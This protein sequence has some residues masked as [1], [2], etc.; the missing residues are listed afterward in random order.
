MRSEIY[1]GTIL[2]IED[3]EVL[4]QL[5]QDELENYGY[6]V[7]IAGDGEEAVQIYSERYEKIDIVISDLGL[8]TLDGLAAFKKMKEINPNVKTIVVSGFMNSKEKEV[9]LNA[10]I[11]ECFSKPYRVREI[12]QTIHA[13]VNA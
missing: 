10:G 3:E 11:K 7:M 6:T 12:L 13:L 5:V 4:R 9:L 1:T 2:F 8:P